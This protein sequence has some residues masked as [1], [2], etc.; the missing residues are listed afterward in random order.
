[1]DTERE[2][3]NKQL[4]VLLLSRPS[5]RPGMLPPARVVSP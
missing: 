3:L 4:K 1:M 5:T 2:H